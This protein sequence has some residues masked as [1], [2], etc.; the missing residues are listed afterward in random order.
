MKLLR[1][2]EKDNKKSII[3][4]IISEFLK[5]SFIGLNWPSQAKHFYFF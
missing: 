1:I 5:L 4:D 2:L 3:L